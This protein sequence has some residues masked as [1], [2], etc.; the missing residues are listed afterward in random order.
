MYVALGNS[1]S[2]LGGSQPFFRETGLCA[3]LGGTHR[4]FDYGAKRLLIVVLLS[5]G[6]AVGASSANG[7]AEAHFRKAATLAQQGKIEYAEQEYIAGLRI[8]PQS[9]AAYN[10][11]GALYFEQQQ[12]TRA[13]DAFGKAGR[14]LPGD[15]EIAFNL[16]L[17][18]YKSGDAAGAISHLEQGQRSHHALDAGLLLGMCHFATHQWRQSI[19]TLEQYRKHAP[20][21]PQVLFILE[22]AYAFA[23][24]SKSSLDTATELLKSHPDS[25]YTHQMLGEAYDRDGDVEHAAE[26]FRQAIAAEP[27]APQLHFMLGYVYWRWKRYP[28]AVA[29]LE[30]ETRMSPGFAASYFYLGDIAFR[31]KDTVSALAFFQRAL[32]L[33][34]SYNDARLG[35]GKSYVQAGKLSEGIGTLR[36]AEVALEKTAEVHYWLG[37]ALIQE[38]RREEG[39]KELGK[40][41]ELSAVQN[42]KMQET[43]NGAPV[44]ERLQS[45]ASH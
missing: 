44:G 26:E 35:L 30:A 39:Q 19:D 24:D 18:L 36:K 21:N 29:P 40:V 25:S 17:S 27:T 37:R 7:D 15:N 32:N 42:Q 9:A 14:L 4:V 45:P 11:L 5:G 33:D 43:L 22:Q 12:F 10:N 6:I 1:I 23:G 8:S 3:T 16:G 38:G 31:K 28:E 2:G 20:D 13:A 34:P 41:R